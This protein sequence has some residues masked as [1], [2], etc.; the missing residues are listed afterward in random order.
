MSTPAVPEQ[1]RPWWPAVRGMAVREWLAAWQRPGDLALYAVFFLIVSSLFPLSLEANPVLLRQ[2]GP[3]VLWVSVILSVL[4]ATARLFQDDLQH[5]WLDQWL[6]SGVPL[7]LLMA[8]RMAVQWVLVLCP[9]ALVAPMVAVQFNLGSAA[10]VTLLQTLVLGTAV[11]V[12][13][14][15][16]AAALSAGTRGGTMLAVLLVLPLSVPTLVFSSLAVQAVERGAPADAE[17]ALLGAIC[18]FSGLVCPWVGG[19]A[20][21][22][23]VDG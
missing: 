3:G 1:D 4:L 21:G 14:S 18:L 7:A 13:L 6:L 2:I 11:L 5:G 10:I 15:C 20:I 23:A 17:L 12:M 9:V 22:A 8:T 19:L 16:V